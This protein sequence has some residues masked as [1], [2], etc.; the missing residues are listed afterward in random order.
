M[1]HVMINFPTLSYLHYSYGD[2]LQ[3]ILDSMLVSPRPSPTS[4]LSSSF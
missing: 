2:Y 4:E 1:L 3:E